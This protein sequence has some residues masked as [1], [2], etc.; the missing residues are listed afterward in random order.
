MDLIEIEIAQIDKE[1][2]HIFTLCKNQYH[3]KKIKLLQRRREDLVY[4]LEMDKLEAERD[5]E[6]EESVEQNVDSDVIVISDDEIQDSKSNFYEDTLDGVT[7]FGNNQVETINY[8][9]KDEDDVSDSVSDDEVVANFKTE[10]VEL[11]KAIAEESKRITRL[12][13]RCKFIT[14]LI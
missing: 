10:D 11:M 3:G 4:R 12:N 9:V 1:L 8:E 6:I 5:N 7:M 14:Y 13:K 2:Q